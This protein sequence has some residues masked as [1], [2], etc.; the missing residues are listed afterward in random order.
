MKVTRTNNTTKPKIN[1]PCIMELTTKP[2]VI[3]YVTGE[4]DGAYMGIALSHPQ[5]EK[6]NK[7]ITKWDMDVFVPMKEGVL[8][9]ND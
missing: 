1:F 2:E 5:L 8:L 3:V 7:E 4:E 9:E 6:W